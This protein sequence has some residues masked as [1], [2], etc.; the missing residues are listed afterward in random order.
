MNHRIS[1]GAPTY[2]DF[3]R[4]SNLLASIFLYTPSKYDFKVVVLDDG[5][6]DA[7]KVNELQAVCDSYGVP[8]IKHEKNEGIPKSWNDLTAHYDDCDIQVLFNDDVTINDKNWLESALYVFDNNENIGSI[9]WNTIQMDPRTNQPKEGYT[10]PDYNGVIGKVGSPVGC[11]F[12]FKRENWKKVVYRDG[13]FGFPA[14][15]I[16]SFYEETW[17]N[18]EQWKMGLWSFHVPYPAMEH[19]GSQTFSNNSELSVT[20]FVDFLPREEYINILK[21]KPGVLS[22]PIEEHE[23][24]ACENRAYRMDYA[25]V[26]F[27][28]YWGVNDYWDKP[29]VQVHDEVLKIEQNAKRNIKY[30]NRKMQECEVL[31]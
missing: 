15:Y 11:S 2:N 4:V 14:N 17:A 22:L 18:F 16:R 5:T 25:R 26:I 24:I 20:N 13:S 1:I 12:I 31:A 27:A 7:S 3:E 19:W 10:L 6:P 23:R 28:K 29:Q 8:L 9:G 30:L 21:Q